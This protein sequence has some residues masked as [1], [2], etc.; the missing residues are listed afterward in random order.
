MVTNKTLGLLCAK[1]RKKKKKEIEPLFID[2][3]YYKVAGI[4]SIKNKYAHKQ[5]GAVA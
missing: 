1:R 4:V 5:N 2:K 3:K